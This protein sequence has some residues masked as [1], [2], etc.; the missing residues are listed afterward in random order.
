MPRLHAVHVLYALPL[1]PVRVLQPVPLLRHL[2]PQPRPLRL[3]PHTH[4]AP[5]SARAA[6]AAAVGTRGRSM[7]RP[8]R[9]TAAVVSAVSSQQ[10][11]KLNVRTFSAAEAATARSRSL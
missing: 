1:A 3:H 8:V 6:A 7:S 9:V 4:A 5:P 2:L 10:Q 11:P